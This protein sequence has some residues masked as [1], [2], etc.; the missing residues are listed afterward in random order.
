MR[1]LA[2]YV[3]A[4][5]GNHCTS[6]T[7]RDATLL[8]E[9]IDSLYKKCQSN[10][11]IEKRCKWP[12]LRHI[13]KHD[14]SNEGVHEYLRDQVVPTHLKIIPGGE[15]LKEN[16][17]FCNWLLELSATTLAPEMAAAQAE[18]YRKLPPEMAEIFNTGRAEVG[19][20]L[21]E[22]RRYDWL[23]LQKVDAIIAGIQPDAPSENL[24]L[25]E[26]FG[27][28]KDNCV[29][30]LIERYR[31]LIASGKEYSEVFHEALIE[32]LKSLKNN[33]SFTE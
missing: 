14:K 7:L 6:K 28:S 11:P 23:D 9:K 5:G 16:P 12:I 17:A 27:M 24:Q 31:E 22:A 32:G 4:K 8:E 26:L 21:M 18:L 29:K 1:Q 15:K 13:V 3:V 33:P 30:Y 25:F 2:A 19:K 10:E 20:D